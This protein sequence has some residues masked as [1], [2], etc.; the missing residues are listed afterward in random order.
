MLPWGIHLI[1]KVEAAF[2]SIFGHQVRVQIVT[3]AK[4]LPRV[5]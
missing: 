5:L 1:L 4:Q 2:K 3:K